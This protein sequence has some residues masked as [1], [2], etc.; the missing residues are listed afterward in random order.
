MLITVSTDL[1]GIVI[2]SDNPWV[3]ATATLPMSESTQSCNGSWIFNIR[4]SVYLATTKANK[5]AIVHTHNVPNIYISE[6]FS[7]SG[8]QTGREIRTRQLSL[9]RSA[10]PQPLSNGYGRRLL[11]K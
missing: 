7:N 9:V 1:L 2:Y 8:L 3:V 10:Q 11:Q 5:H 4:H 6:W